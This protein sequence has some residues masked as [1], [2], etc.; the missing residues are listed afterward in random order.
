MTDDLHAEQGKGDPFAA[1]IRATRM[2]MIITDPRKPDNPIVFAN[3][4]FLKLSGYARD[5]IVGRNCRFLQGPE[6]DPEA[7][8]AIRE[9][10]EHRQDINI[11]ILNYR[12]DGSTFWNAL[13]ISPVINEEGETQF[14]FASQLDVTDRKRT[15]HENLRE[16]DRFE[17]AV[18]AR[19]A[20]LNAALEA[21]T[22]LLHEVDHRVKNNLQMV[23]SLILMQARTIPD[24]NIRQSLQDML[25][26]VEALSTV[27]RRFYQSD[28]V[29]RFD[30]GDFLKDLVNDVVAASRYRNMETR[31]ELDDA[32]I[33]SSRA[34]PL[35][36]IV[37]EL[38]TNALKHAFD[39]TDHPILTTRIVRNGNTFRID[40]EDN[41]IGMGEGNGAAS[42]GTKL[43]RSLGRQLKATVT[44][45]DTD[46]GTRATIELP[47][48]DAPE[49]RA[50]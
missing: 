11:D 44:W 38:V 6:S 29:A 39:G 34:A 10:I 9:A 47:Q 7:V 40:I 46:P 49:Q 45:E 21:K 25:S 26:R 4:A 8:S 17:R 15:E 50:P 16:K 2:A 37:N 33:A 24:E 3:D 23:S 36:L 31:F 20:E 22:A 12:K 18:A 42:F 14:F 41:G 32:D 27:H 30:V 48:D 1:A 5:E 19:T 28:D 35:A 43:I 13:Y